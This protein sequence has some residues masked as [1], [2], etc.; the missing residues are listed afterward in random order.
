MYNVFWPL[1]LSSMCYLAAFIAITAFLMWPN[2][3][4]EQKHAVKYQRHLSSG[5]GGVSDYYRNRL[6]LI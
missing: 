4:L 6:T 5:F 1:E 3:I 2:I